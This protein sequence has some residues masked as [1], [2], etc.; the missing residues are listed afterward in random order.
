M[1]PTEQAEADWCDTI[2][3]GTA[4]RADFFKECTPG[5]YNNEGKPSA[6]AARNATYGFGSPAFIRILEGW[7][8]KGEL[9]GLEVKYFDDNDNKSGEEEKVEKEKTSS[10]ETVKTT[11]HERNDSVLQKDGAVGGAGVV[12]VDATTPAGEHSTAQE[13]TKSEQATEQIQAVVETMDKKEKSLVERYSDL[14]AKHVAE[15]NDLMG[16]QRREVERLLK[17]AS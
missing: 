5:Y 2:V 10:E 8:E 6:S 11:Q 9:E 15:M 13:A 3:K 7:R 16:K 1:E 14:Q 12:V 17:R 4:I